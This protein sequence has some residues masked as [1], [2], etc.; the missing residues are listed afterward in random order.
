[1]KSPGQVDLT[2]RSQMPLYDPHKGSRSF[3]PAIAA[4]RGIPLHH[5]N[6][7]GF[8]LFAAHDRALVSVEAL[9]VAVQSADT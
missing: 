9:R 8:D 3:N 4:G 2:G 7:P 6:E 1:M 5:T